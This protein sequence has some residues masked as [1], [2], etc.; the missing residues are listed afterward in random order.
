M[1]VA[2]KSTD[3]SVRSEQCDLSCTCSHMHRYSSAIWQPYVSQTDTEDLPPTI[4]YKNKRV[5]VCHSNFSKSINTNINRNSEHVSA[6]RP[7]ISV[8]QL[9]LC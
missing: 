8:W 3:D 6:I 4:N 5:L 9:A 7:Q 2:L 1:H